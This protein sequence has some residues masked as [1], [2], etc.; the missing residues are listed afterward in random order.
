MVHQLDYRI[1]FS[2]NCG[3]KSCPPIAFY[4]AKEIDDQ[5]NLATRSF[6]ESETEFNDEE[7][8]AWVTRIFLWFYADFGGNKGIRAILTEQL[9]RDVNLYKIK[10]KS[11]SWD[12]DLENF[13]E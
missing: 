1:H 2:L 3:A 10:Y 6:L 8:K 13:V 9:G 12:D 4:R 5:L 7:K 11:Y